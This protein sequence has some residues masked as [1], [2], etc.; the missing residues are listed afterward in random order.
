M[1]KALDKNQA[2]YLAALEQ[3]DPNAENWTASWRLI[4]MAKENGADAFAQTTEG[5]F[6]VFKEL[7]R[8]KLVDKQDGRATQLENGYSINAA[9]KE[10]LAA[11]REAQGLTEKNEVES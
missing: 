8:R 9:G 6:A 7:Y 11:W 3:D 4:S 2:A 1:A 10:A 5:A